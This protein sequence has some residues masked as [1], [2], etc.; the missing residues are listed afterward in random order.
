MKNFFSFEVLFTGN[1]FIRLFVFS[2]I[3]G[4]VFLLQ[5]YCCKK[6]VTLFLT[7]KL[8]FVEALKFIFSLFNKFFLTH[9]FFPPWA[10]WVWE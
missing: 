8:S 9:R 2:E 10:K 6:Q 7:Q 3:Q 1:T 5:N 4:W